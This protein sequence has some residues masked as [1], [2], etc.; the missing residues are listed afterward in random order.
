MNIIIG[1]PSSVKEETIF[2]E[3]NKRW[4]DFSFVTTFY[5]HICN[6]NYQ[7]AIGE[8]KI[9]FCGQTIGMQTWKELG[10]RLDKLPNNYFSLGQE[11]EYYVSLRETLGHRLDVFLES[12]NDVVYDENLFQK[13]QVEEVFKDSLSRYVSMSSIMQ[14]KDI[15]D[16]GVALREYGFK[17]NFSDEQQLDFIVTPESKPPTNVH[18]LIGRN[19]VGKSSLLREI[20]SN[21]DNRF[22]LI[23]KI[24]GQP[25]SVYD[26]GLLLY[27][28]LSVFDK[29]F[30]GDI[31]NEVKF[32]TEHTRKKY[33]GIY[34]QKTHQ[35]KD[36]E[37][38]LGVEFAKSLNTCLF[39]SEAKSEMWNEVIKYLEAD[40]VFKELNLRDLS[41]SESDVD[42]EGV[43]V[44]DDE[45]QL[46]KEEIFLL[47][48]A[49]FFN[50]LSSGHAAVLYYLIHIVELIEA[51]TICIFDEPENHLHP[52][53]LSSFIRALSHILSVSNG[54]AII[55]THSPV[56][57][58]E[59]PRACIWKVHLIDNQE[60][61]FQ[62]P[63]IETFGE[64]VGEI[65]SEVFSL[66][67]RRSGFYNLLEVDSKK[68]G[69][70]REVLSA[71]NNQVGLEGRA[72]ILS[73]TKKA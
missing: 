9:G 11:P 61:D 6:D 27:F 41:K 67:L 56:I 2:L 57:L 52:P 15:L 34:D 42:D 70:P 68:I 22:G 14:F 46:A 53:L 29:P 69:D 60:Y 73:S 50:E 43:V 71:Y 45:S 8:M 37:N 72:I 17:L 59:I 64:S 65:T 5:L 25:V 39:G 35:L 40:I 4:N 32:S 12:L 19:G 51:K 30:E 20:V 58:Q 3:P 10:E 38:D 26:Y 28:S 49:G 13:A 55:A 23:T 7:K 33:I 47:K 18:V 63:S 24:N 21:I 36:L 66:D 1:S 48:A 54:M 31:F 44:F 16:T 62:R